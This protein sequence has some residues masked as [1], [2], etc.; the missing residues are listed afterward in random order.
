VTTD[1]IRGAVLGLTLAFGAPALGQS[2]P[3]DP[4]TAAFVRANL[5]ATFYHEVGHALIDVLGLPVPSLEEDAADT[6]AVLLIDRLWQ[7]EAAEDLIRQTALAY[8]LFDARAARTG[9]ALPWWTG[10]SLDL[11]RSFNMVCLFYGAHAGKGEP[12]ARA[13]G[14]PLDRRAVC[15][16]GHALAL[17]RWNGLLSGLP[18]QDSA[19]SFRI[20]VPEDRDDLAQI[21]AREVELLNAEFGLSRRIDVT[22]EPCGEA[23]AFYDPRA[24]RIIL[25]TEYAEDLAELYAARPSESPTP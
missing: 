22:V 1:A 15:A 18:P 8:R 2:L 10:H 21:L 19:A 17:G 13:L 16:T 4:E 9:A 24:R 20:A 3:A 7:P 23:N 5:I 25:C 11:Q 6:L 12:L 14:L